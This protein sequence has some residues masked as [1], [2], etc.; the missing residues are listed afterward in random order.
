MHIQGV[1][2]RVTI[3]SVRELIKIFHNIENCETKDNQDI[4]S[5]VSFFFI[6]LGFF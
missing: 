2:R 1:L 3:P 5:F 4:K 6:R